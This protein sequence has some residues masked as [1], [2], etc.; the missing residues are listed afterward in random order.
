M[1]LIYTDIATLGTH[2]RSGALSPVDLLQALLRRIEA[3]DAQLHAF[4]R[5]T[6]EI[7]MRQARAAERE[8][9]D[10]RYRGPLHGIPYALKD[11][12]DVA[13]VPTTAQSRILRNNVATCDAVVT[14]QLNAA[15]A[16][17]VGKLATHE[18]AMG[19]PSFDLPWPPARNPWNP[20]FFPGGS[21]SGSA[22]AV[23]AGFVPFA[24]GTDTRGSVRNPASLC[25]IV[26]MKPTYGR[27]SCRGVIPLSHS[28]DHVGPLTRTVADNALVL[29]AIAA[30]G[31]P[32]STGAPLP[33]PDFSRNLEAGI[34][35]LK[36]GV[37][38]RFY[39]RDLVAGGDMSRGI[40]DCLKVL[41]DLG[42]ILV[43]IDPGPLE[44]Y[45]AVTRLIMIAEAY[46]VHEGWLRTRPNDY[47]SLML[48]RVLAGAFVSAS[49]YIHAQR[50]RARLTRRFNASLAGVDVAVTASSM[51]PACP[52]EDRD[53][54][55][56]LY[57]RH[58]RAPFNLTGNPAL[59]MPIG[60]SAEGLPLGMQII[61]KPF[62][63]AM[64]YRLARGYERAS[65]WARRLPIPA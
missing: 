44:E 58:A 32:G 2:L 62:E 42:A 60:F 26:G 46:A 41:E 57:E 35:G 22:V 61:G 49:D 1:Q 47:G 17:C 6:P 8:M 33:E 15:G 28:L 59:S 53:A 34:A 23:A 18:F 16:V 56:R 55:Q 12:I 48:E 3:H 25:G 50:Q 43:E 9:R 38:R 21:S 4:L 63:E 54:C 39:E 5:L 20:K 51:E 13:G 52:I 29:A 37:I 14:E 27:V 64:V 30:D 19:G 7:A 45:N 40:A 36:V 24:I 65:E 31:A 10:H 11:I